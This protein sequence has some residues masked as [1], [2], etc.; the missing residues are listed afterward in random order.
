[1]KIQNELLGEIVS[2]KQQLEKTGSTQPETD[3]ATLLAGE[4]AQGRQADG[5]LAAIKEIVPLASIDGLEKSQAAGFSP[6]EDKFMDEVS[7]LLDLVDSYGA[8]LAGKTEDQAQTSLKSVY[9]LLESI[10]GKAEQLKGELAQIGNNPALSGILNELGVMAA[11]EKFKL[12]RG[13]YT[14]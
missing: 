2:N 5:M 8:A 10:G 12:N 14:V 13:D 6:E 3:F 4:L 9:S 11:T 7:E 1:M